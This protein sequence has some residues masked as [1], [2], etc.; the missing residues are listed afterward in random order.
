MRGDVWHVTPPGHHH[1]HSPREFG[2]LFRS[3]SARRYIPD[4]RHVYPLTETQAA[5]A[6]MASGTPFGKIVPDI[7]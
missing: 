1:R 6:L 5:H 2:A 7:A 4:V 3:S